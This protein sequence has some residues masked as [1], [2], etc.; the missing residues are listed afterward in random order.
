MTW[1]TFDDTPAKRPELAV[2]FTAPLAAAWQRLVA[3]NEQGAGVFAMVNEGDGKGRK[4]SNVRRVRALFVDI[5]RRAA[6][7]AVH[8]EPSM[9]VASGRGHHL[10]WGV[11]DCTTDQ[12]KDAQK[13]L[14]KRYVADAG[15]HDLPR[16]MR[17]AGFD[18]RKREPKPVRVVDLS[19]WGMWHTAQVI[20]NLPPAVAVYKANKAKKL[21]KYTPAKDE[22]DFGQIDV[23]A[24]FRELTA[25][26]REL[27]KGRHAVACPWEHEHSDEAAQDPAADTS[28]VVW[29]SAGFPGGHPPGFRCRHAH[30]DHRRIVDVFRLVGILRKR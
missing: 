3:L 29:E 4:A 28:T 17:V 19:P 24:L 14:I 16:V 1:Q 10:Y 8:M 6:P 2:H 15:V 12:F 30:C 25:V 27:G 22:I 9:V 20:A 5:D 11:T 7:Q 21:G 26:G 23:L 18:H 13:R